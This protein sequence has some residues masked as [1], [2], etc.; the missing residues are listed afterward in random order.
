MLNVDLQQ[1]IAFSGKGSDGIIIKSEA[2]DS[3][4]DNRS[5]QNVFNGWEDEGQEEV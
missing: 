4:G 3:N 1:M 5:R 2:D